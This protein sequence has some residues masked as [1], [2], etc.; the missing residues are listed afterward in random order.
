MTAL[1]RCFEAAGDEKPSSAP[2]LSPELPSSTRC[3]PDL[4]C[5]ASLGGLGPPL[6]QL[7]DLPGEQGWEDTARPAAAHGDV[8]GPGFPEPPSQSSQAGQALVWGVQ[9]GRGARRAW[10]SKGCLKLCIFGRTKGPVG[11]HPLTSSTRRRLDS[12]SLCTSSFM[13]AFISSILLW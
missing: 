8:H 6:P 11:Q 7:P 10:Q 5:S 13:S 3:S 4:A 12:S 2:T 1:V 9:E